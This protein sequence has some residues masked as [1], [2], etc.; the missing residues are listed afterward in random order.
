MPSI[1][2]ALLVFCI[3][4]IE[5]V[6]AQNQGTTFEQAKKLKKAN[7]IYLINNVPGIAKKTSE[8][9]GLLVDLM[10]EFEIYLNDKYEI[11]SNTSFQI[12]PD[13]F[14]QYL[15]TIENS[16][17]GVFALSNLSITQERLS[18]FDFSEPYM[19]NQAVLITHEK[20]PTLA[21]LD[22]IRTKFVGMVP[23]TVKGS[24]NQDF[25]E[26]IKKKYYPD[27]PAFRLLKTEEDVVKWVIDHPKAYGSADVLYYLIKKKEGKP[28][29]RH[30]VESTKADFFG[31]AMPK[32]SDWKPVLNDFLLG[33][34][35]STKYNII[36]KKHLGPGA[37]RM[38]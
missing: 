27:M 4:F 14:N 35:K 15:L 20:A 37:L 23:Y 33:F 30:S 8:V 11:Q 29:K 18:K 24:T 28:L 6:S 2:T 17:G 25:L 22:E 26:Q 10:S 13:D 21:S 3:T 36:V 16:N 38:L 19:K 1:K 7:L 31:I 34:L 5:I 32:N 9:E 12:I